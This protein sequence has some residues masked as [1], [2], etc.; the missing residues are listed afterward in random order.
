VKKEWEVEPRAKELVDWLLE[1][2]D[3]WLKEVTPQEVEEIIKAAE[4][5]I[6]ARKKVK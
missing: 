3:Q 4:R 1:P 2:V 5:R 6:A